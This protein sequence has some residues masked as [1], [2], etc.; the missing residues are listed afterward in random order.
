MT[1]NNVTSARPGTEAGNAITTTGRCTL[2][3]RD[4]PETFPYGCRE[5]LCQDCLDL[6]LDLLAIAISEAGDLAGAER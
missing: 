6:N 1:I 5:R 3:E 2:C 4:V